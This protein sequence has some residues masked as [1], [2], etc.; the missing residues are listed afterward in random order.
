[1][2]KTKAQNKLPLLNCYPGLLAETQLPTN[3]EV[4]A[5]YFKTKENHPSNIEYND[6]KNLTVDVLLKIY[7]KVPQPTIT[8][9]RTED[10]LKNL[11][12]EYSDAKVLSPNGNKV[13]TFLKKINSIFDISACKCPMIEIFTQGK[14]TCKCQVENRILEEEY[15]FI[16]DQRNSRLMYLSPA[17]D[18]EL[19]ERYQRIREREKYLTVEKP[20]SKSTKPQA[21]P[22]ALNRTRGIKRSYAD[23][24]DYENNVSLRW[25]GPQQ[26]DSDYREIEN[27]QSIKLMDKLQ[28]HT[29][30]KK[31]VSNRS[32]SEIL[33]NDSKKVNENSDSSIL[34]VKGA[35]KSTVHNQRI[36][37]REERIKRAEEILKKQ[38]GPVQLMFDGKKINGR[39]RMVVVIQYIDENGEKKD[40]FA[41]LKSFDEEESITGERLFDAIVAELFDDEMLNKVLC[42][43]SD[44]TAVNTGCHKGINTRVK[45]FFNSEKGR[46]IHVFEC[47]LH[48]NE[49]FLNHFIKEYEGDTKAPNKMAPGSVYNLIDQIKSEDL[50]SE[51]LKKKLNLIVVSNSAKKILDHGLDLASTWKKD[52]QDS[53]FRGD[54]VRLLTLSCKTY[55]ALPDNL[56]QYIFHCQETLS[57]A[58]WCTTASG[59]LRIFLFNLFKLNKIQSCTLLK[60]IKF[61][62]NVYVPSFVQI[63]LNPSVPFGPENVLVIRD[64]MKDHGVPEKVK[65]IFLDHAEKW[66]SP[67]NTAVIVHQESPP[68]SLEDVKRIR[69]L[70]T[71]TRELCWSRK[72]VQS[73]LTVESACAPCIS[74]GSATFW[75]RMDNHNRTCERYIGKMGLVLKSG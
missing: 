26:K 53:I 65:I 70:S 4:L 46:D 41:R 20:K 34:K 72:P 58:R 25:K 71:N 68:V 14:M 67:V 24:S 49:L 6:I 51:T 64:L 40:I 63:N 29:S 15:R 16:H 60:I 69:V 31:G 19:T 13:Q 23:E 10:K 7:N 27:I 3:K 11:I 38:K 17:I 1:M 50:K 55:R 9:K 30:D 47:L 54:H 43:M 75:Q 2:V 57:Q 48:V 73:F 12:R 52:K 36:K 62:V 21:N 18:E 35:S 44:T 42:L 66:L 8:V 37:A 22:P 59:Y 5:H 28:A 33:L 61:I 74:H 39:E 45:I 32:M 56:T